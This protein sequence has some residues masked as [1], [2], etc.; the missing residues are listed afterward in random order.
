MTDYSKFDQLELAQRKIIHFNSFLSQLIQSK[1]KKKEAV[2]QDKHRYYDNPPYIWSD[3]RK[4]LAD[5]HLNI[6]KDSFIAGQLLELV[7]V[8]DECIGKY[9]R[10]FAIPEKK[11]RSLFINYPSSSSNINYNNYSFKIDIEFCVKGSDYIYQLLK[12][13]G[14]DLMKK[15]KASSEQP[16]SNGTNEMPVELQMKGPHNATENSQI[17]SNL[18][19][20]DSGVIF[21]GDQELSNHTGVSKV[22]IWRLKDAGKLPFYKIGRKCYY[23]QSEIDSYFKQSPIKR[24]RPKK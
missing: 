9:S 8:A 17:G 4:Y 24:G 14:Q 12:A 3:F 19:V 5:N 16:E 13:I 11:L 6:R 22:T 7:S 20:Q 15:E 2:E 10:L 18:P 1:K 21:H 23:K